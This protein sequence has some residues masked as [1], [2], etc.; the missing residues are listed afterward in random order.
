MTLC[1]LRLLCSSRF[2]GAIVAISCEAVHTRT[3]EAA[4]SIA[5]DSENTAASV[6]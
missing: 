6:V 2:T 3:S 1:L 4:W 5:T